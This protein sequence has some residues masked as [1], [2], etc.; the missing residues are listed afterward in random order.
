VRL[1][2]GI[3]GG[4]EAD[5]M[6]GRAGKMGLKGNKTNR[7]WQGETIWASAASMTPQYNEKTP[8]C[9][10]KTALHLVFFHFNR[11]NKFC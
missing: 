8:K 6:P 10:A 9:S 2:C 4:Q 5:G 1:L 11:Y 3:A 7:N